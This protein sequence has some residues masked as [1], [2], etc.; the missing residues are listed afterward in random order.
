MNEN[1]QLNKVEPLFEG[2]I[3]ER[4]KFSVNIQGD[5][6][7]GIYH[8]GEID[9]YRPHPNLEKGLVQAVETKVRNVMQKQGIQMAE[10]IDAQLVE[11]VAETIE[12]KTLFE[13]QVHERYRFTLNFQGNEFQGIYHKGKI[14]WFNPQPNHTGIT[15]PN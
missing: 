12:L 11:N 14:H 9:W 10:N 6:F 15:K 8:E 2:G 3:H 13:G 5:E 7:R 4:Y 1:F